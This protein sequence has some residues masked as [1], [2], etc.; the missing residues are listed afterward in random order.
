MVNFGTGKSHDFS[1]LLQDHDYF[2]PKS[3]DLVSALGQS[4]IVG[5][6]AH[7]DD[8]DFMCLS[9]IEKGRTA[10]GQSTFFGMI[11]SNGSGSKRGKAFESFSDSDFIELRR[12]EQRESAGISGFTGVLQFSYPSAQV[13]RK[14]F[15]KLQTE[16]AALLAAAP[17]E[18]V[19]THSPFDR[20]DTHRAVCFHVL[21]AIQSLPR[22][23]RPK[24][25]IGCEVWRSLDWLPEK[26]RKIFPI[27][28]TEP[29]MRRLFSVYQSQILGAKN[30]VDAVIG[31]KR[32][33]ATFSE[34]HERDAAD[35]CEIG[36]DLSP[37]ALGKRSLNQFCDEVL[38]EFQKEIR[39]ELK[40][41]SNGNHHSKK[42]G[43]RIASRRKSRRR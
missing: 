31:R 8:L 40:G 34:S 29:Q 36:V 18:A 32:S 6:G 7:S 17:V 20:H 26:Y 43:S 24:K 41:Y 10:D 3:L 38:Q 1:A 13:K 33:H 4:R 42:P 12:R 19:F 28:T 25:V 5:I 15:A 37:V 16:V 21:S 23:R 11:L 2:S 22:A 9:A 35:F 39:Q 27:C 30:Y 14:S